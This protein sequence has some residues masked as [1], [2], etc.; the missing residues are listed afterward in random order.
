M[1][2]WLFKIEKKKYYF[3]ILILFIFLYIYI[4]FVFRFKKIKFNPKKFFIK[5]FDDSAIK[6]LLKIENGHSCSFIRRIFRKRSYLPL[7][8][9]AQYLSSQFDERRRIKINYIYKIISGCRY[10]FKQNSW[11]TSIL[12]ARSCCFLNFW[13]AIW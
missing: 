9:L 5:K 13:V 10:I 6:R 2:K 3:I 7:S 1:T 8:D 12:L 4:Y 11:Y